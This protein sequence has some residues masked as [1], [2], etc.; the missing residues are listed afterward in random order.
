MNLLIFVTVGLYFIQTC[1][2]FEIR[3]KKAVA[4][5]LWN[6]TVVDKLR[7]DLLTNYDRYAKPN[8]HLEV[9]N[10]SLGFGIYYLETDE[11][12]ST[13]SVAV[14]LR[15]SW[16]DPKL[17]WNPDSY[18]G[19]QLLTMADH[20]IWQ[21]DLYLLNSATSGG[22]AIARYGNA[23]AVVSS[24]GLIIWLTPLRFTALC[25]FDLFYWP[26]DTQHCQLKFG[27]WSHSGRDLQ[28]VLDQI[29]Y[30]G[31]VHISQWNITSTA[32]VTLL[33]REMYPDAFHQAVLN[34]TLTRKSSA[35]STVV[36][37]AIVVVTLLT[38][39]FRALISVL[40]I[41]QC[42]SFEYDHVLSAQLPKVLWNETNQD[43]LHKDLFMNYDRQ[44]RPHEPHVAT[45]VELS[46]VVLHVES[47]EVKSTITVHS[48]LKVVW[49]D[50]KLK[51]NQDDYGGIDV[52]RVAD[53]ELWHPDLYLQNSALGGEPVFRYGNPNALVQS[54]GHVQIVLRAKQTVLCDFD[55]R[56]WPFD[57]QHCALTYT[58][59]VYDENTI[60]L[61]LTQ[62]NNVQVDTTFPF[63]T[64]NVTKASGAAVLSKFR[65]CVKSFYQ[66]N[67]NLTLKR[68]HETYVAVCVTPAVVSTVLISLQFWLPPGSRPKSYINGF[69]ILIF[70]THL[71]YF[72]DKISRTTKHLPLIVLVY[73]YNLYSTCAVLLI[74]TFGIYLTKSKKL[75]FFE[76]LFIKYAKYIPAVYFTKQSIEFPV[77]KKPNVDHLDC[78]ENVPDENQ[79]LFPGNFFESRCVFV[80]S[81]YIVYCDFYI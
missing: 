46:L 61:A 51:W 50:P 48:L 21:P 49:N 60:K 76:N 5:P 32:E 59:W 70:I 36:T 29:H 6:E 40:S 55:L 34:L 22:E 41:Y 54:N 62:E 2:S 37:T 14:E 38:M 33:K 35:M 24:N 12:N 7:N 57:T 18:N 26:Y 72:S 19:L 56:F 11:L 75:R 43:K 63:T 9:S 16:F 77:D 74:D 30:E 78:V 4:N 39:Y 45:T 44:A 10:V 20:E 58:S 79:V 68:N 47:N 27:S 53:H 65:C 13:F 3:H 52:L 67:Y 66:I 15:L 31:M 73:A 28:L 64:W 17:I 1:L 8:R 42:L 23:L 69:L 80:S 25:Q 81:N 71:I